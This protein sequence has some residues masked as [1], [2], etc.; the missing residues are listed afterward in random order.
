M[1][2]AGGQEFTFD[3]MIKLFWSRQVANLK[4]SCSDL[5]PFANRKC[6]YY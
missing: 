5:T 2:V 3:H 4:K 1:Y 6:K